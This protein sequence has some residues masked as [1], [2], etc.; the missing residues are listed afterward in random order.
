MSS[1]VYRK[2]ATRRASNHLS[3]NNTKW[4]LRHLEDLYLSTAV[5]YCLQTTEEW[6]MEDTK[7]VTTCCCWVLCSSAALHTAHL[8]GTQEAPNSQAAVSTAPSRPGCRSWLYHNVPA[9]H[10][11]VAAAVL[12]L[13]CHRITAPSPVSWI[14]PHPWVVQMLAAPPL[15]MNQLKW[16]VQ[17]ISG[18]WSRG[19]VLGKGISS[20][21]Q[22]H[23]LS[24]TWLPT[25]VGLPVVLRILARNATDNR[26]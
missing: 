9:S 5:S 19:C 6:I 21:R 15:P 26:L 1:E 11:A 13:L 18:S 16:F 22:R 25:M 2:Q 23:A 8:H 14:S 24:G 10:Y 17:K 12:T 3:R 7:L 4:A 20:P